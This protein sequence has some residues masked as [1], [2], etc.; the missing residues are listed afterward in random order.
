MYINACMEERAKHGKDPNMSEFETIVGKQTIIRGNLE[1][2]EDLTVRGRVEGN[3][4][5]TSTLIIEPNGIVKADIDVKN[6]V[7]SGIMVG[8][9]IASEYVQINEDGR[10]AGDISAPRVIIVDGAS[11]RG[12]VDMGDLEAPRKEDVSASRPP[13]RPRPAFRSPA[14]SGGSASKTAVQARRPAPQPRPPAEP[15][16]AKAAEAEKPTASSIKPSVEPKKAPAKKAGRPTTKTKAAVGTKQQRAKKAPP[17]PPSV[18]KG[19]K[20]ARKKK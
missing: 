18:A 3:I 20:K 11:F 15:P 9:I 16:K 6:A 4:T 8:N 10:M 13:V 1:G 5:L 7:V 19:K 12:N 17:K 2:D 14:A